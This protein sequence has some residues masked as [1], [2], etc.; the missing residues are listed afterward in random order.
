[1]FLKAQGGIREP[2]AGDD[3]WKSIS[4]APEEIKKLDIQPRAHEEILRDLHAFR[5]RA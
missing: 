3:S 2:L 5:K 1:L 4:E